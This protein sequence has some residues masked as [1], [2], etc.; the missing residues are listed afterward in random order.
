MVRKKNFG[1]ELITKLW[2]RCILFRPQ[3]PEEFIRD[4]RARNVKDD[5]ISH[6]RV[7]Q[8]KLRSRAGSVPLIIEVVTIHIQ[9][10]ITT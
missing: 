6:L 1:P 7:I 9:N 2:G 10:P 5:S 8:D 4:S 3:T